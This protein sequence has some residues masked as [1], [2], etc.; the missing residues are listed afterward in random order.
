MGHLREHNNRHSK[1][2]KIALSQDDWNIQQKIRDGSW[3]G[4][5]EKGIALHSMKDLNQNKIQ[6][7]KCFTH[8]IY[9]A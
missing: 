6:L 5:N 4:R 3:L 9:S 8:S 2:R 7:I 1:E